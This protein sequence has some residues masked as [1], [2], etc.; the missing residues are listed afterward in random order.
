MWGIPKNNALKERIEKYH[1]LSYLGGDDD[2]P[3][4]CKRWDS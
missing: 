2:H 4:H 1:E 3:Y